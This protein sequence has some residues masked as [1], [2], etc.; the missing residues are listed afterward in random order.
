MLRM[1]IL[2]S[3]KGNH[4]RVYARVAAECLLTSPAKKKKKSSVNNEN[5]LKAAFTV[6]MAQVQSFKF[7]LSLWIS[8][9]SRAREGVQLMYFECL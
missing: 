6:L 9:D 5:R 1:E 7:M 8:N 3:F 4:S 2:V